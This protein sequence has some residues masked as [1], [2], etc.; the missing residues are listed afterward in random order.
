MTILEDKLVVTRLQS[1]PEFALRLNEVI[2]TWD[3]ANKPGLYVQ[4]R[5]VLDGYSLDLDAPGLRQ[6]LREGAQEHERWWDSFSA[7]IVLNNVHGITG[8]VDA[9]RPEWL[10]DIHHDAHMLAGVWEFPTAP[11]RDGETPAIADWY[12]K[13]F[14]QFFELA[15]NALKALNLAGEFHFTATLVNADRLRYATTRGSGVSVT[16]DVCRQKNVQWL[17]YKAALGSQGWG[18]LAEQMAQGLS[19]AYRVRTR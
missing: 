1:H 16:G 5:P 9:S 12:A 6:A 10:V 18:A 4:A 2:S 19:G 11:T 7:P 15:H 13:F 3:L 14:A 8:L 17:V